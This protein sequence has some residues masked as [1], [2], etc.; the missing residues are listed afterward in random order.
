V[1]PGQQVAFG[2]TVTAPT[3]PATYNFQWQMLQEG[4]VWFG[5]VT[6]NVPVT[7]TAA[8]SLCV[9]SNVS[10]F[11]R[12]SDAVNAVGS[13]ITSIKINGAIT[14]PVNS[15][16]LNVTNV[17][18]RPINIYG[19][20]GVSKI[21][22]QVTDGGTPPTGTLITIAQSSNVTIHDLYIQ[23]GPPTEYDFNYCN[24]VGVNISQS[25]NV[26]LN[27]FT[28][29]NS[30]LFGVLVTASSVKLQNSRISNSQ[31]YG[32]AVNTSFNPLLSTLTIINSTFTDSWD[33][34]VGLSGTNSSMTG[35]TLTNNHRKV[36]FGFG[37]GQ[38]FTPAPASNISITQNTIQNGGSS[39]ADGIEVASGGVTN[40]TIK[41]NFILNNGGFAVL[42]NSD[43][44]TP[45]TTGVSVTQ[46]Q[47]SCNGASVGVPACATWQQQVYIPASNGSATNNCTDTSCM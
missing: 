21:L 5:G 22:R 44:Q 40:V 11:L 43:G 13:L 7:V 34:A 4:V 23:D 3:T 28:I 1:A 35:S 47:I 16:A 32:I 17:T 20:P 29:E 19:D 31:V 27:N 12:C 30:K 15:C 37:G 42:V 41:K 2:F 18:N 9:I 25:T 26:V 46:N 6:P 10:D 24:C 38:I 36:R 8:N 45:A 39:P 14:C 33:A